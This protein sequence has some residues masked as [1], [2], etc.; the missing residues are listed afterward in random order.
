[1]LFDWLKI[2][3]RKKGWVPRMPCGVG[4]MPARGNVGGKK[5]VHQTSIVAG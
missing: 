5:G 3:S 4:T 1:M 2:T